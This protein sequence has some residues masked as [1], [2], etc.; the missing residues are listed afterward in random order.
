MTSRTIVFPRAFAMPGFA[1]LSCWRLGIAI[2]AAAFALRLGQIGSPIPGID[3]QFYLLVGDRMWSGALPYVDIWD[4]KPAGL[5]LL[6]AAFRALPGDGIVAYQLAG[7]LA[8]GLTGAVAAGIART[9]LP[10]YAAFIAGLAIVVYGV[11]LG[12]GFGEAPIFYDLLIVM[13]GAR[14][15]SLIE[16]ADGEGIDPRAIAAIILCGVALT[17]KT[18]AVFESC[19]FGALLLHHDW[20]C[21]R[22][23]RELAW[24][25]GVYLAVGLAPTMAI[26]AF[27]AAIGEWQAF[28]FANLQSAFLRSAS[29]TG[30]SLGRLITLSLLLCPLII[31][32]LAELRHIRG[33]HRMVLVAWL[34]A[35]ILSFV[36]IGRYYEHYA[37]PL[38]TPLAL[39][40]AYGFR[41]R[42]VAV[43]VGVL[44]SAV[45]LAAFREGGA[46][47][48]GDRADVAA[49]LATLPPSVRTQCLFV[50]EG[51]LI[52]YH[53][54]GACLPGRYVFAGHFTEPEEDGALEKPMAS[55]LR[56][57]L[58]RRPAAIVSVPDLRRGGAPTANDRILAATLARDYRPVARR[59]LRLYAAERFEVVVW[60][61][62]DLPAS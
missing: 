17:V 40:A 58:A 33:P 24:R 55:I 16:R 57:T 19:C 30:D 53:L 11:L 42:A 28:A 6:Y 32:A 12:A 29:A 22:T 52:L 41:R 21:G 10:W 44:I 26:A 5:F 1:S 4:R 35:G 59:P 61:R 25:G 37:L 34:A 31:P 54:S 2:V 13:A 62:R 20:R 49:L 39:I 51:P 46:N 45:F 3:D 60:R 48:R 38:V 9:V 15:L 27:Y 14:I 36:A 43:I 47:A 50:Y 56:E 23:L 7:T 18:S 8:L